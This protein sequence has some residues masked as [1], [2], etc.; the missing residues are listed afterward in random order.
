LRERVGTGRADRRPG[1][2]DA[3]AE[4]RRAAAPLGEFAAVPVGEHRAGAG[5]AAVD[6]DCKK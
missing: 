3:E 2:L 4:P 5:A 1:A 6:A